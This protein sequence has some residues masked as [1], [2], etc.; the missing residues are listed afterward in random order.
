M[1]KIALAITT[2]LRDSLLEAI[3]GSIMANLS[4]D[5]IIMVGDQSPSNSKN[6]RY[7]SLGVKYYSL[8]Y[9][10]GLSAARN[11]LVQKAHGLGIDYVLISADS[12]R[13][14]SKYN[15]EIII[16]F[17]NLI[18]SHGIVG[19]D[20]VNRVPWEYDMNLEPGK[21]FLLKKPVRLPI[22][23]NNISFQPVDICRNFFLAKTKCLIDNPWDEKLKMAEHESFFYELKQNSDYQ[24][25]WTSYIKGEYID[26]KPPKYVE[27][28]N[29][30]YT[31]YSEVLK[32]K[33]G[34]SNKLYVET[35]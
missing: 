29:R 20:I 2:F 27:Y 6:I 16:E 31:V 35:K 26:Y 5:W 9:D 32:K 12:I 28:R 13:F 8:P 22:I 17:L 14:A 4:K 33:Y 21:Y 10:C 11:F 18:K 23:H 1:E 30:I 15:I 25:F 3:V 19:F 34:I 7:T 24:V